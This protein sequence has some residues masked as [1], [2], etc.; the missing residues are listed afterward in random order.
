MPTPD[1]LKVG[2][3]I[4]RDGT[5]LWEVTAISDDGS[6][7]DAVCVKAPELGWAEVGDDDRLLTMYYGPHW[8]VQGER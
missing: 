6:D 2:V 4:S 5:D 7:F 3:L 1:W 8:V